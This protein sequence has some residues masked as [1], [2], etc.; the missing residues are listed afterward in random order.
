MNAKHLLASILVW[1]VWLPIGEIVWAQ[2]PPTLTAAW[3]PWPPYQFLDE[4]NRLVGLDVDLSQAIAARAGY[5]IEFRQLPWK[6]HLEHM[7]RGSV[8]MASGISY[9]KE[10]AVFL[11]Y[12]KPYRM[13]TV[14]LFVRNG[15]AGTMQLTSL[16]DLVG[17]PYMIGTQASY[18]YG[19]LFETLK[20]RPDF[21]RH[22]EEV[23]ANDINFKKLILKRVDGVLADPFV[24]AATLRS[25]GY[26]GQV[27][28]HPMP[29]H[30]AEIHF[31]FS[32]QSVTPDIVN[33]FN[34]AIEE[35]RQA[36]G[37]D[38]IMERWLK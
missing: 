7:R 19:E 21:Q 31:V 34:L 4:S 13:E 27:E 10:R 36:G 14:N 38:L 5:R 1:L 15:D 22:V 6:R 26:S 30:S 24:A 9:T 23:Y 32:R 2:E 25:L 33:A 11:Q 12:S 35:E 37:I 29:V 17:S 20:Q 3:E 8:H 18:Y 28:R 16:M